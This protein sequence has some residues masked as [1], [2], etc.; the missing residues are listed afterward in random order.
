MKKQNKAPAHKAPNKAATVAEKVKIRRLPTGV[1]GLDDIIGGGL[2]ELS[3]NIIAGAPGCGKTTLAHQIVFA[4]ATPRRPALDF[5][6]L[7]EPA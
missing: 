2:P 6:V 1:P 4:N 3:F 7:G 5:T